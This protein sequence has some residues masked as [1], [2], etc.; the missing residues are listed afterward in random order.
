[1]GG[2]SHWSPVDDNPVLKAMTDVRFDVM[3]A[4]RSYLDLYVGLGWT[5]SVLMLMET[6]VLWQ[7]ASLAKTD[8]A[9]VQPIIA[10]IT[11]ANVGMGL[12]AARFIFLVPTVF[13]AVLS[14]SLALA[15]VTARPRQSYSSEP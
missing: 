7:L 5:I 6:I 12:I 13:S 15:W 4:S 14:L 11:L 1:M 8:A 9:R 2:L 10:V 3:G